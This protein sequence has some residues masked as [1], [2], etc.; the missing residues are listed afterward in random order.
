MPPG[1]PAPWLKEYEFK[2]GAPGR[3][4]GPNKHTA[5]VRAILAGSFE[6]LG[7][8]EGFVA[9]A[10]ANKE[11]YYTKLWIKLL[12][13]A[14]IKAT[15]ENA[16]KLLDFTKLTGADLVAFKELLSKMGNADSSAEIKEGEKVDTQ[17][18]STVQPGTTITP[19]DV[20]KDSA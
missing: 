5:I 4:P 10:K 14:P 15:D 7:G 19:Q 20:P 1:V 9:W 18:A 17:E 16:V 12:P 6:D 3:P 8:Y 13:D 11:T 2:K